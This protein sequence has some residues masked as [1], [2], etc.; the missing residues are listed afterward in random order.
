M[1]DMSLNLYQEK[2]DFSQTTEPAAR[3]EKQVKARY[4]IQKH[5]ASQLHY[6]FRLEEAGVLKSWAVPKGIPSEAGVRRLAVEVEDHP[7]EYMNFSGVIPEGEYGAETVE[8]WDKGTYEIKNQTPNFIEF[9]LKGKRVSGDFALIR[10]AEKNWL[11]IRRK[12][13]VPSPVRVA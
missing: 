5:Q 3:V 8:I 7:V 12:N 13:K 1:K 9:T 2:R 6:D 10:M 11:F 4:V